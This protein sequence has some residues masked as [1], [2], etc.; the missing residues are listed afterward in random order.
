MNARK[1]PLKWYVK[2]NNLALPVQTYFYP[3]I[4]HHFGKPGEY[5]K[6]NICGIMTQEC[7]PVQP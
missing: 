5:R 7:Y 1:K 6:K 3:S 2:R 4:E